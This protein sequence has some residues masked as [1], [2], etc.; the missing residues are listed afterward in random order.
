MQDL[1]DNCASLKCDHPVFYCIP[2][3]E[4][5]SVSMKKIL[6]EMVK[7]ILC[8]ARK[9]RVIGRQHGAVREIQYGRQD[10]RQKLGNV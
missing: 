9:L 1:C 5:L 8:G 7:P 6:P 4:W 10:G 3:P 2:V